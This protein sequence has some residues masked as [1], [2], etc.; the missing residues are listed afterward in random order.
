MATDPRGRRP[1]HHAAVNE[2]LSTLAAANSTLADVQRRLDADFRA[3]YPDHANPVKLVARLKRIQEEVAAV[4]GLCRDL[5][6]Q[7][8]E[9][10]DAMRTS[11]AVQRS[12]VQRLLASSGLPPMSEED[13]ATDA[14][15]NQIIDEWTAHVGPDTGDDKDEDTNQIFFAA[16]V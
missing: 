15:L 16:V 4:K 11:L 9:L 14:N 8:Q 1:R 3:A 10:I 12:A 5:L 6:T 2:V 7:K 13:A